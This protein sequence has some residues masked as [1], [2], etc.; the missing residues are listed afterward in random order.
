MFT[1]AKR[2]PSPTGY[3][4]SRSRNCDDGTPPCKAAPSYDLDN[5]LGLCSDHLA[6][7]RK[8]L[9]LPAP[10]ECPACNPIAVMVAGRYVTIVG[11]MCFSCGLT[12]GGTAPSPRHA[13]EAR[14]DM[15]ARLL[16][17]CAA[18]DRGAE[19]GALLAR[20]PGDIRTAFLRRLAAVTPVEP[21]AK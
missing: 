8:R 9:G 20:C 10:P 2:P 14:R 21:A 11:A 3:V 12:N 13:V 1:P 15:R 19:W 7:H 17:L 18:G 4:D 5:P 6:K 16:V